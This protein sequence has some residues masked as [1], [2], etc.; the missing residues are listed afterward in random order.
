MPD[1][2]MA[3]K[4][5]IVQSAVASA[6]FP[7][8][9]VRAHEGPQDG[10]GR[11]FMVMDRAPGAPPL[12]G[13]AGAGAITSA[14]KALRQIPGL[15]AAPMAQ[16]HALDAQPVRGQ[17]GPACGVPVTIPR[18][19]AGLCEAAAG[20]GR[21]DLVAAA[22]WLAGH[23]PPPTLEVICHGDL[24][25]FN[26]LIEGATVTVVDW[27]AALLAPRAY[28]VA[29]TSLIL[30]EPP[31]GGPPRRAPRRPLGRSQARPPAHRPLPAGRRRGDR[32]R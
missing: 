6:G 31:A 16:L 9:V 2:G 11:A 18:M 17:L 27:S 12:A 13:L 15:L 1:A 23:P 24:H 32:R 29:F 26:L 28:D 22:Q 21:A 20:Y 8:P 5:T 3:C 14:I 10:L 19:L 7:T 30:A 25:P 4:E